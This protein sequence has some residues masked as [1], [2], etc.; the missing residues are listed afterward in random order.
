[1]D[2]YA[3][4]STNSNNTYQ[5]LAT[6]AAGAAPSVET[7]HQHA[8][9]TIK[10]M[11]GAPVPQGATVVVPVEMTSEQNGVVTIHAL[12]KTSNICQRGEDMRCGDLVLERGTPIDP[13]AIANLA[14]C[15]IT[16]V[17]V[18]RRLRVAIIATGDEIADDFSELGYGENGNKSSSDSKIMN[19][20]S[21]MLHALCIKYE[22]EVAANLKVADDY[23][24]TVQ[25]LQKALHEHHAD[26]VLLSGGV[27]AGDF[28]YVTQTL[29]AVGAK[30]HFN[31]VAIKPGKPITFASTAEHKL[32]FGLPGNPV[33]VYLT[34]YLFVLRAV[35]TIL[36]MNKITKIEYYQFPL[37]NS[38]QRA[39]PAKRIEYIPC[40][41]LADG[42]L[43]LLKSHGSAH[44][45][46]LLSCDGFCVISEHI[47]TIARGDT[48][49]FFHAA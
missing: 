9:T 4:A 40:R 45:A 48:V 32:I 11:T 8:R 2:G 17:P 35:R 1:M 49:S 22:L 12:P 20:N 33:S 6:V 34:F 27:S 39:A 24:L 36:G 3:T 19:S 23:D 31:R 37:A 42:T 10:V 13:I 29:A 26:I 5:L 30:I 7:L 43:Q 21:P 16:S 18:Q 46:A 14:A 28:D 44:L 38:F 15:G 25:T 47:T 41:L